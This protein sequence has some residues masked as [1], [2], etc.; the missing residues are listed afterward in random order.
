MIES[1]FKTN[2]GLMYYKSIVSDQNLE[3]MILLHGWGMRS[4]TFNSIAEKLKNEFNIYILDFLG[5]GKSD[6]PLKALTVNDYSE[7]VNSFLKFKKIKSPIIIGHSFGG[8]VA[9]N[10][11]S[12][13]EYKKIFLVNTPAFKDKTLKY[14]FKIIKYKLK[15]YFYFIFNKNKYNSFVRNSGSNDYKMTQEL[16]KETFK[17]IVR[18]DLTADLSKLKGNVS[19]LSSINDQTVKFRDNQKMYK[20]IENSKIY[21]FYNSNHFCYI[22][23]ENK[24]IKIIRKECDIC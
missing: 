1:Y 23:E 5:F 18:Y 19:I 17:N 12:K 14:Y 4:E 15:K 16:M 6:V 7:M 21:T 11:G 20:L 3:N 9:I 10:Y 13:Y 22:E 24:F 2:F 8:R